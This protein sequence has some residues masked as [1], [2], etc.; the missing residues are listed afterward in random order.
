MKIPL[1]SL[2]TSRMTL[3]KRRMSRKK[4]SRKSKKICLK[5]TSEKKTLKSWSQKIQTLKWKKSQRA[6][7]KTL[8]T[9]SHFWWPNWLKSG[10]QN[11]CFSTSPRRFKSTPSSWTSA[12][13]SLKNFW[14][15][16]YWFRTSLPTTKSSSFP[17]TPKHKFTTQT[18]YAAKTL[19]SS[20]WRKWFKSSSR[21]SR[22]KSLLRKKT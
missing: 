20:T 9:S 11:L 4:R 10:P 16:F 5:V 15:A 2:R 18:A 19:S 1:K 14:G 3:R 8:K 7:Q 12:T 13:F 21:R 22:K 6:L 17:S